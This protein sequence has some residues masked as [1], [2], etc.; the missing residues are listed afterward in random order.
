MAKPTG[1]FKILICFLLKIKLTLIGL[2]YLFYL[3]LHF[4]LASLFL[5]PHLEDIFLY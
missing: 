2:I 4:I 3:I 1:K 5:K